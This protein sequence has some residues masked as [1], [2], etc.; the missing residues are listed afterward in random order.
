MDSYN[1]LFILLMTI[2]I[3]KIGYEANPK[4]CI[5]FT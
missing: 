5:V 2:A 3:F 1:L 4:N